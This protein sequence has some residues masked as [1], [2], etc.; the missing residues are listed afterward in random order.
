ML[1]RA[2]TRSENP[3]LVFSVTAPFSDYQMTR[4]LAVLVLAAGLGKRTRVGIPKVLLPLCGRSLVE[5]VLD[6]VEGLEPA[7]RVLVLH[8]Q[9]ERVEKAL[10]DRLTDPK[11]VSVDQG[12]P[13][14]TGHAVQVGMSALPADFAGDVLVVYGDTPLLTTETLQAL[15][16]ARGGGACSML[17]A[18]P[19][20]PTGLGRILRNEEGDVLGIREHRDCSDEEQLIDEINAGMY[21][22]D[23]ARLRGVLGKLSDDNAQGELYLTDTTALF[24]AD[25]EQVE[26]MAVD[27][28]DE[29]QGVNTLRDLAI[30]RELMQERIL[31]EHLANGVMIEDPATTYIDHGVR[32]GADTRILPCTVIRKGCVVGS[33]CEVGPFAQL[34]NGAV[35]EDGAEIGNFVEVKK[36][37]LGPGA[38]AKHLAYVGDAS[39]GER[40]NIGAGTITAN[41]DGKNKHQT[42]VGA[43][44][45]V[46]SG[47]VLV[48]PTTVGEGATTGAGAIVTRKDV[49]AGEVWVGVPARRLRGPDDSSSGAS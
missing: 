14:G 34:R 42:K 5:C 6:A 19:D 13:R 41:Y 33:G 40:A 46:G 28:A 49:P 1:D 27:D 17:T 43:G 24:L 45:F 12:Q 37:V 29:I 7:H 25:G 44:A 36:S 26:T 31:L 3:P 8:N 22:F 35:L 4:P 11:T 21:C 18:F 10:A 23:A 16:D 38:K 39:I 32:I 48:A 2:P 47:T 9:K 20:D 30:A 15:R